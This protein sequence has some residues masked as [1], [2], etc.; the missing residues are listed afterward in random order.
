MVTVTGY[1]DL[2]ERLAFVV[3]MGLGDDLLQI[4]A[5]IFRGRGEQVD[6]RDPTVMGKVELVLG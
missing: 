5:L 2:A 6:Q 4:C 1:S 3:L